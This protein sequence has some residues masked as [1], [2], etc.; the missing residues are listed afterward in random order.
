[1][2]TITRTI[3]ATGRNYGT[4]SL[5]RAS[6]PANL[7]TDNNSYVGEC[8][9]DAEFVNDIAA[10]NGHATDATHT[11]ALTAAAGQ[12]FADHAS[13]QTNALTYNQANGVGFRTTTN[14]H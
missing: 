7:V 10:L 4:L 11:I 6:L 2:A 14:Y 1:M 8:Y 5:W 13:A 12:S 3:G 9:N